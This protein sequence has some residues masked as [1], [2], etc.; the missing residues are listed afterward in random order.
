MLPIVPHASE[1]RSAENVA[2]GE[3][4]SSGFLT[5]NQIEKDL[6][7]QNFPGNPIDGNGSGLSSIEVDLIH[8]KLCYSS[9]IDLHSLHFHL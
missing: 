6:L 8:V 3:Q 4:T 7:L 5:I 9:S 1:G 2:W